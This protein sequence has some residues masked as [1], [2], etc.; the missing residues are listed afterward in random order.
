MSEARVTESSESS[1]RERQ[2]DLKAANRRRILE[3]ASQVFARD[4]F[5]GANLNE[6][7]SLAGVGKGT[8][9]RHFENK[10]ALFVS[11]L[12]EGGESFLTE[13]L[14]V[15]RPG[16]T[17]LEQ[18]E[19]LTV[20][21]LEFF[22]TNPERFELIWAIHN[23]HIIGELSEPA[24]EQILEVTGRPVQALK[25][26][27]AEGVKRGELGPCDPEHAAFALIAMGNACIAG[28]LDE[29]RAPLLKPDMRAVYRE[30]ARLLLR[31]LAARR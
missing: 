7:A 4:G 9:Y 3:A 19:A 10:T 31:G 29:R 1:H 17:I 22:T 15:L 20:F 23:R 8:L 5:F 18:L 11:M 28:V 27:I 24:R 30:A 2:A 14:T 16:G 25:A 26:L 12:A 21:Y 6:V 13:M